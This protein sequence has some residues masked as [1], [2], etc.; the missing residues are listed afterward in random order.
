MQILILHNN[1]IPETLLSEGEGFVQEIVKHD[2]SDD[3]FDE[4][5]HNRLSQILSGKSYDIIILPFSLA[6]ENYIE[7]TGL[8]TAAHIRLTPE[9]NHERTPILFIGPENPEFVAKISPMGNILLTPGVYCSDTTDK[10]ALIE[11]ATSILSNLS[12]E[13]S[14]NQYETFLSKVQ[15]TTPTNYATHHTIANEWAVMR[16]IDMLVWP[17]NK[18]PDISQK[19]FS[20][21]LYFKYLIS[22]IKRKEGDREI[23]NKKYKKKSANI[24]SPKIEGIERKKIMLIDDEFNKGWKNLLIAIFED[25]SNAKLTIYEDFGNKNKED[26]INDI[27]TFVNNNDAD[28]YILDLRLHD[29]DY[30]C[31][32]KDISGHKISQHILEVNKANPIVVFTASNK[33]W[34]MREEIDDIGV[35]GY[36]VKES[37]EFNFSCEESKEAFDEF[38]RNIKFAL[39]TSYI[40]HYVNKIREAQERNIQGVDILD[41]YID[42]LILGNRNSKAKEMLLKPCILNLNVF[43]ET[44]I[45]NNFTINSDC[46]YH[47]NYPTDVKNILHKIAFKQGEEYIEDLKFLDSPQR[48]ANPWDYAKIDKDLSKITAALHFYYNISEEN[49]KKVLRLRMERSK[50]VAHIGEDTTMTYNDLKDIFEKVILN[51]LDKELSHP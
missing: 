29:D 13:I 4:F 35:T 1:N 42:M 11:Y 20:S 14:G 2:S 41:Q 19:S 5:I 17:D 18:K 3:N 39:K 21:M 25:A 34:N 8:I 36:V 10:Q 30:N 22:S 44:F 49:C 24:L 31:K 50:K 9:W 28:C 47:N 46:L 48:L 23:F 6:E 32:Y 27:N 7:Y 37:P 38:I 51:I 33:V 15:I 12:K 40:K 16:W 43:L 45:K 26:L